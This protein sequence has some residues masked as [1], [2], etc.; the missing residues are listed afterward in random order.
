MNA[1]AHLDIGS[2][3]L[4]I[5]GVFVGHRNG[6]FGTCDNQ[7][8]QV[9]GKQQLLFG[10]PRVFHIEAT[11]NERRVI[12][13]DEQALGRGYK[14]K[15]VFIAAQYTRQNFNQ[16]QPLD[17]LPFVNPASIRPYADIY[18]AGA[19]GMPEINRGQLLIVEFGDQ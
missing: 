1:V 19:L 8:S 7:L 3:F 18:A 10:L 17:L 12:H 4:W 13:F 16:P 11:S 9:G 2:G 15:T 6:P 5:P 14:D